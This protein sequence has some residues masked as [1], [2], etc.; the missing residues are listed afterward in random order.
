MVTWTASVFLLLDLGRARRAFAC[1]PRE[2]LE[3]F[4]RLLDTGSLD[5]LLWR[6]LTSEPDERTLHT[7][8]QTLEPGL[9]DDLGP[10]RGLLM[11]ERE[12]GTNSPPAR[13]LPRSPVRLPWWPLHSAGR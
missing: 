2:Y 4:L 7:W 6:F 3:A 13:L 11:P 10:R 5:A 8:S 12:A 9:Y 1:V